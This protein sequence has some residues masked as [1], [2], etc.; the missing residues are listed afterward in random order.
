MIER[1]CSEIVLF[2]FV[3]LFKLFIQDVDEIRF[4]CFRNIFATLP[5]KVRRAL[6]ARGKKDRQPCPETE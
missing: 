6:F 5:R 1:I 4:F 2:L 3:F